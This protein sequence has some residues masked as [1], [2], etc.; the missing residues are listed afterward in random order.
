M[1][2]GTDLGTLTTVHFPL[3]K[4]YP[5]S[6]T[7]SLPFQN[8]FCAHW[9][10]WG[11]GWTG[12]GW[13]WTTVG[14]TVGVDVVLTLFCWAV[15]GAGICTCCWVVWAWVVWVVLICCCCWGTWACTCCLGTTTCCWVVLICWVV[16]TCCWVVCTCCCGATCACWLFYIFYA[17][18]VIIVVLVLVTVV[19]VPWT[20]FPLERTKPC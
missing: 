3:T 11:C 18:P 9:T 17:F 19:V 4:I 15:C 20:H 6:Q 13:G 2:T 5:T 1:M 14:V 8:E 16:C 7:H 12:W 10:G